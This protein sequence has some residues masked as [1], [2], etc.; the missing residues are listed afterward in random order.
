MPCCFKYK[1]NI[2]KIAEEQRRRIKES[3]FEYEYPDGSGNL[4]T[5]REEA[6]IGP[7][8]ESDQHISKQESVHDLKGV[9]TLNPKNL[10]IYH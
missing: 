1:G 4:F 6:H 9:Y 5:S 2:K 7:K 3:A 10:D 8:K